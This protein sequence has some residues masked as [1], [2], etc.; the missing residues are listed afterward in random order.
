MS[1]I[2]LHFL[3]TKDL[4][5]IFGF[6]ATF[7]LAYDKIRIHKD[8]AMCIVPHYVNETLGSALDCGTCAKDKSILIANSVHNSDARSQKLLRSYSEV[9]N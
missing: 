8:A 1:Q 5:S 4:I 3:D 2:K 9:A 6:I 7:K